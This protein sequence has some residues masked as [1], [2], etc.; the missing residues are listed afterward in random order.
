MIDHKV[1]MKCMHCGKDIEI[2]ICPDEGFI[3]IEESGVRPY[4]EHMSD[5]GTTVDFYCSHECLNA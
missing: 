1:T 2:E 5:G 4:V 3:G